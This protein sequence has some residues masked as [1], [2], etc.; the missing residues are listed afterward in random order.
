[1]IS[2]TRNPLESIWYPDVKKYGEKYV[3]LAVVG[4]QCHLYDYDYLAD[5]N[6][7]KEFAQSIGA[8][9]KLTSPKTGE[10]V[11]ELFDTLVNKFLSSEFQSKYLEMKKSKGDI[12][13]LKP[14]EGG[15]K[16]KKK[17]PCKNF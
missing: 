16:K 8:I 3:I 11:E 9:F 7:A 10:G 17:G 1:M 13:V 5:E 15:N 6:K 14:N 12:K 4:N 2:Q